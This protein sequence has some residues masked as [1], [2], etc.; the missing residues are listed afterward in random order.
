MV[1]LLNCLVNGFFQSGH[2]AKY[3]ITRKKITTPGPIVKQKSV[4]TLCANIQEHPD[5][6]YLFDLDSDEG[7]VVLEDPG[8]E[9]KSSNF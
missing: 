2:L 1:L 4:S 8:F 6:G 3:I 9:S 5:K 7:I